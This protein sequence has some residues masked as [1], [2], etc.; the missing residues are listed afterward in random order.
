MKVSSTR[1]RFLIASLSQSKAKQR[2]IGALRSGGSIW[3]PL[4]WFHT[5]THTQRYKLIKRRTF[6]WLPCESRCAKFKV[7]HRDVRHQQ[8][9]YHSNDRIFIERCRPSFSKC[10]TATLHIARCSISNVKR[11]ISYHSQV[12]WLHR[13]ALVRFCHLFFFFF[14]F[15]VCVCH[16]PLFVCCW[17]FLFLGQQIFSMSFWFI[18][19]VIFFHRCQQHCHCHR[20]LRLA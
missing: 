14:F 19:E 1:V 7:N 15:C 2:L 17:H 10:T 9:I 20:R 5:H 4:K 11:S 6:L 16:E 12:G 18:Y 13:V 8:A 3:F